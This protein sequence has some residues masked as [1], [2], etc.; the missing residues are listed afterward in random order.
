MNSHDLIGLAII[1]GV[2]ILALVLINQ[3]TKRTIFRRKSLNAGE[4]RAGPVNAGMIGLQKILEPA[5]AK[6]VEAQ[7]DLR[8]GRFNEEEERAIPPNQEL[9]KPK[10]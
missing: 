5:T 9:K 3:I 10:D 8:E 6:A 1:A 2:I 7:Q 4:R